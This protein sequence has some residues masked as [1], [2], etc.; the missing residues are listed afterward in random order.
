MISSELTRRTEPPVAAGESPSLAAVGQV[1][2][3]ALRDSLLALIKRDEPLTDAQEEALLRLVEERMAGG[4]R[5]I[6]DLPASLPRNERVLVYSPFSL[7]VAVDTVGLVRHY[8]AN[9]K[10]DNDLCHYSLWQ[11]CPAPPAVKGV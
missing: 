11:P 2:L 5:D 4:W 6:A 7:C 3:P 9:A 10:R 1:G 8:I